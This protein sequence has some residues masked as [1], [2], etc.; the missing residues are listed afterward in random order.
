M[1]QAKQ[2][3][4]TP[5]QARQRRAEAK[6]FLDAWGGQP[7]SSLYYRLVGESLR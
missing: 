6:S 5:E 3:I 7:K 1:T 4:E 2:Q